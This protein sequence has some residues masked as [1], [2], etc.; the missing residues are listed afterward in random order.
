MQCRKILIVEDDTAM[1]DTLAD[2]LIAE[3]FQVIVAGDGQT[4][5]DWLSQESGWVILLDFNLPRLDG[6]VVLRQLHADPQLARDNRII[7]ISAL[8]DRAHAAWLL[9]DLVVAVLPKPFQ[10]AELLET[11]SRFCKKG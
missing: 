1:R 5:L 11:I 2:L 4:A 9:S 7:L 8:L 6:R 3:G 10:F